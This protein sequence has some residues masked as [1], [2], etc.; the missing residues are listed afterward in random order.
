MAL[1]ATHLRFAHE[2]FHVLR[3]KDPSAYYSGTLYPDSRYLTGIKRKL[4]HE[5]SFLFEKKV[6]QMSDFHKGWWM[7][8]VCDDLQYSA[9]R[10]YLRHTDIDL[11]QKNK[12]T[13]ENTK[14]L[15]STALKILQDRDDYEKF[16]VK[17]CLAYVTNFSNP[18]AEWPDKIEEYYDIIKALYRKQPT[19]SDYMI[20]LWD[21]LKVSNANLLAIH[22]ETKRLMAMPE[23]MEKV[24]KF[25]G[26][27]EN[28]FLDLIDE[29]R[30]IK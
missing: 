12:V 18:N 17:A 10:F 1:A 14:F 28:H 5:D 15:T 13:S 21:K 8:L 7:H 11:P 30:A 26:F 23:V 3:V 16:E 25:F 6:L 9:F 19:L 4:T 2:M 24:P 29:L 20:D 22:D 27:I